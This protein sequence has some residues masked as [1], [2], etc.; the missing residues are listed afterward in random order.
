MAV[1][2]RRQE[3]VT[4]RRQNE[5]SCDALV[6]LPVAVCVGGVPVAFARVGL[7]ARGLAEG[8]VSCV[9]LFP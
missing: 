2:D 5:G 8:T 3:R 6:L 9:S 4:Q 7:G 1:R